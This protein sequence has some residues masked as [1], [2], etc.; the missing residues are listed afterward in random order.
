MGKIVRRQ[1]ISNKMIIENVKVYSDIAHLTKHCYLTKHLEKH[2]FPTR[3]KSKYVVMNHFISLCAAAK[4]HGWSSAWTLPI[5]QT[6]K[7]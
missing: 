6:N 7:C 3:A 2:T 5:G 1:L 4:A